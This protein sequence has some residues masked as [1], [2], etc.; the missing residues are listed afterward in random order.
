MTRARFVARVA[1]LGAVVLLPACGGKARSGPVT[2]YTLSTGCG[3]GACACNACKK[4]A[5]NKLFASSEAAD[6]RRAHPHCNC[7][8]GETTLPRSQWERLFG[9]E[10]DVERES[11]DRRADWVTEILGA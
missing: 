4:H 3:E 8:I 6:L 2:A 1:A 10:D 11:V 7:T 5:A 9:S